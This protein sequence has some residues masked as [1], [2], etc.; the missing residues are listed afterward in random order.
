MKKT[1][2]ETTYFKRWGACISNTPVSVSVTSFA[3][4]QGVWIFFFKYQLVRK[5]YEER[6]QKKRILF[7][8]DCFHTGNF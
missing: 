1:M 7:N 4:L 3:F 5:S 6:F 8:E 2:E